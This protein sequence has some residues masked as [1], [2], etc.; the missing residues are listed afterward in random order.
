MIKHRHIYLILIILSLSGC[1]NTDYISTEGM[2]V[3]MLY[4]TWE[5][6]ELY[7][8]EQDYGV[9][10]FRE[11]LEGR[12]NIPIKPLR[13][14]QMDDEVFLDYDGDKEKFNI[15]MPKYRLESYT[16]EKWNTFSI[17]E[18]FPKWQSLGIDTSMI[19]CLIVWDQLTRDRIEEGEVAWHPTFNA[20]FIV[21]D[22]DNMYLVADDFNILY[23]IS[24]I[25]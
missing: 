17:P 10:D 21:V 22:K 23:S 9:G 4:G 5:F 12:L 25:S 6:V 16:L 1:G 15:V 18:T 8:L 14:I 7:W 11:E 3:Q 24:R 2:N 19:T 20:T 13:I